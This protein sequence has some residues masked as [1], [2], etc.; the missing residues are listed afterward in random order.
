ML[1][2]IFRAVA[3]FGVHHLHLINTVALKKLLAVPCC[4][5]T[6]SAQRCSQEWSDPWIPCPR[7][8]TAPAFPSIRGRSIEGSLCGRPAG[9]D[10][11]GSIAICVCGWPTLVVMIGPEAAL[12][13]SN[14]LAE[15]VV[16]QRVHLGQRI[17]SVTPP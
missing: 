6:R 10:Q 13:R 15:T 12:C 11:A 7:G 9:C 3:E 17:L 4:T 5:P 8:V 2:R 1:R 16:A 14:L